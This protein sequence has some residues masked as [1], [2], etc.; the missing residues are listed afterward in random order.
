MEQHDAV[1]GFEAQVYRQ[2]GSVIWISENARAV[3]DASGTLLCYEGTVEDITE[4]K[5]TH[6]VQ[7]RFMAILEAT[8]DFVGIA[9]VHGHLLYFNQA[10]RKMLGLDHDQNISEHKIT[11]FHPDWANE[12]VLNEG[13]PAA[14]SGKVWTGEMALLDCNGQ[15]IA[16]SQV[17]LAHKT[18]EGK[19][20]FLATVIRDISDRKRLKA[21]LAYLANHDPL[22]GLFN[23]RHF[24]EQ[25]ENHLALA[26]RYNQCGALLFVDLDDFKN[27]NDTLGH[28]AGDELLKSLATLLQEN[29][30][31]TDI[32]GRLGGDEFA[33]LL[34][35]VSASTVELVVQWLLVALELHV[36][37]TN[38]QQV[39]I[40]AS[41]GATLFPDHGIM[42][43]ELLAHADAAMYKS[44]ANGRNCLSLYTPDRD[45]QVQLKSRNIWKNRICELP[46]SNDIGMSDVVN[47]GRT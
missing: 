44:K 43:D 40:T 28:Q 14:L 17:I 5:Q 13:I 39:R 18:P 6:E 31:N 27:I 32:L 26:Q 25:L 22:T 3:R 10:G 8:T 19:V 47:H 46:L 7:A 35:Q 41:I 38:G 1:S 15:E 11:D 24:Q 9:D 2:D 23:R 33:I 45:C 4:H 30:R 36:I 29:L 20:E 16:V 34:P 42:A 37:V 12:L 21:Q